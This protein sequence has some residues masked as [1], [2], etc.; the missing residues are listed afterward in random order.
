LDGTEP[1]STCERPSGEEATVDIGPLELLVLEFPRRRADPGVIQA[2]A[3][4]TARGYVT[5]LDLIWVTHSD[6]GGLVVVDFDEDL[7]GTGL[8]SFEVGGQGLLSEEDLDFVQE[9]LPPD[10]S[11][12]VILYE[13]T[14]A[15]GVARAIRAAGG[16]VMIHLQLPS[17]VVE[18][19]PAAVPATGQD[20]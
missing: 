15:R 9:S 17:S 7:S 16:E 13:E 11:A 3:D 2:I 20:D 12:A 4:L 14:W 18:Q 8:E 1:V 19:A 10:R 5:I 6:E